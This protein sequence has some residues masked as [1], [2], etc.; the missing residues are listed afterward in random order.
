MI[1]EEMLFEIIVSVKQK[2][3]LT[4]FLMSTCDKSWLYLINLCINIKNSISFISGSS[5]PRIVT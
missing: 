4:L 3:S 2:H 1:V 5:F